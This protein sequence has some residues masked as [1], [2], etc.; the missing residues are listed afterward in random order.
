MGSVV[1]AISHVFLAISFIL[2][3]GSSVRLARTDKLDPLRGEHGDVTIMLLILV[4][5]LVVAGIRDRSEVN[6]HPYWIANGLLIPICILA[7]TYMVR[8]VR[9]Y[10]GDTV[11]VHRSSPRILKPPKLDP[12]SSGRD[13]R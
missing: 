9:T 3:V 10:R 13:H 11:R 5:G 7:V 8:M 6:S 12:P 1:T 2:F 4:L